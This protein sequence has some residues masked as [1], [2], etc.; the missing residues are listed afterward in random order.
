L[1]SLGGT[2]I[3]V[4]TLASI[5]C[6]TVVTVQP[7]TPTSSPAG[8]RYSLPKPVLHVTPADDG[9]VSVDVLLLPDPEKT[10][11]IDSATFLAVHS[12]DVMV[13]KG[14]LVKVGAVGDSTAVAADLVRAAGTVRADVGKQQGDALTAKRTA[15]ASAQTT[16]DA[17]ESTLAVEQAKLDALPPDSPNQATQQQAVEEK[18]IA[19]DAA[20]DVL[21][22]EQRRSHLIPTA[23]TFQA[24]STG[25]NITFETLE[26]DA[27]ATGT[28]TSIVSKNISGAGKKKV[29]G[30][31]VYAVEEGSLASDKAKR[32]LIALR[33]MKFRDGATAV[34]QQEFSTIALATTTMVPKQDKTGE[35][36]VAL[37][38]KQ[39]TGSFE[40]KTNTP[41]AKLGNPPY[42][43]QAQLAD[44]SQTSLVTP[45][46]SLEAGG[47]TV[48]IDVSRMAAGSYT[49][50]IPFQW[51]TGKGLDTADWVVRFRVVSPK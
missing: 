28:I 43:I 23:G 27:A 44:G 40:L 50:T 11:A 7:V 10:Y 47:T 8:V 3:A 9:S 26:A 36:V 45:A 1:N 13:S 22:R 49:L 19:R 2:L 16:L 18:R 17:A 29:W 39:H 46:V 14:L 33:E 4:A 51:V 25:P 48:R 37:D 12:L 31:R 24:S 41:I 30:A 6:T 38:A 35:L 5:G 34:P 21:V 20:R 15:V 42:P 32:P